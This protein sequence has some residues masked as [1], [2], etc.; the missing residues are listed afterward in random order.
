MSK[1]GLFAKL[2]KNIST[3]L[4]AA[5]GAI[6]TAS[7]KIKDVVKGGDTQ[8]IAEKFNTME[9]VAD[10]LNELSKEVKACEIVAVVPADEGFDLLM[11]VVQ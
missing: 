9:D 8:F 2:G 1:K 11:Y 5:D 10:A 6:D 7:D 4:E 3:A